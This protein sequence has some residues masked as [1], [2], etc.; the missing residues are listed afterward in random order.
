M[1]ES[2]ESINFKL[3]KLRA[4]MVLD[5]AHAAT[6]KMAEEVTESDTPETDL[7]ASSFTPTQHFIHWMH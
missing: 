1:M 6:E 7:T 3:E 5:L 4:A 2:R